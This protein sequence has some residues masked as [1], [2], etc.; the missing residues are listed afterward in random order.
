MDINININVTGRPDGE[1]LPV[2]IEA[3]AADLRAEG[4]DVHVSGPR[5]RT[6]SERLDAYDKTGAWVGPGD[7]AS[8]AYQAARLEDLLDR[9]QGYTA[10]AH[11]KIQELQNQNRAYQA[12]ATD[13]AA[14]ADP[15]AHLRETVEAMMR[16]LT[17]AG[18]AP[19]VWT[20]DRDTLDG[21]RIRSGEHRFAVVTAASRPPGTYCVI[22]S[23]EEPVTAVGIVNGLGVQD[24]DARFTD[25]LD[26]VRAWT[27]AWAVGVA[28]DQRRRST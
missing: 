17:R 20:S 14:S 19:S 25:D 9:E 13:Q 16:L 2:N 24:Q 27:A 3:F 10:A 1:H 7:L 18:V 21:L 12:P 5:S 8:L 22:A 4:I 11:R 6:L 23:E 26:V 28:N 15:V